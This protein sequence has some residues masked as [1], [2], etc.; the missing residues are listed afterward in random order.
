VV[1]DWGST[2]WLRRRRLSSFRV[3]PAS[4]RRCITR[5]KTSLIIDCAPEIHP[6]SVDRANH[7]VQIPT[8]RLRRSPAFQ[9]PSDLRA[10]LDRPTGDGLVADF[11]PALGQQLFDVAET[12][13]EAKIELHRVADD[14]RRE[15]MT[16][17]GQGT[18][19]APLPILANRVQPRRLGSA[20][21]S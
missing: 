20:R 13:G 11:D 5:S 1:V 6:T 19:C 15:P 2:G 9:V 10:E 8:R 3:A 12:Q 14:L 18:H 21:L 16:F 4:R 17:E 7:L